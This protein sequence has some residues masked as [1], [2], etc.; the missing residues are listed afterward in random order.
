MSVRNDAFIG[1]VIGASGSGK[2]AFVKIRIRHMQRLMIWDPMNEYGRESGINATLCK[3]LRTMVKVIGKEKTFAV[4][5]VPMGSEKQL[6]ERFAVFCALAFA[7]GD[8]CMVIEEIQQVTQAGRAPAEWSNC[9]LRGRHRGLRIYGITQ[10]PALVDKNFFSNATEI[11]C[12]RLNFAADVTT[13]DNV[14]NIKAARPMLR[15]EV[16]NSVADLRPLEY[17][18]RDM[19]T[20]AVMAG[21]LKFG[22]AVKKNQRGKSG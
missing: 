13:M 2:S 5:Y 7:I 18:S 20:G 10:R 11:R 12:G 19:A 6:A 9:T 21:T 22:P 15:G 17:V 4:R 8:L 3:D 14:L 1:A 16:V